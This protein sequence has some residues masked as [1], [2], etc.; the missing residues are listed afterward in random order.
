VSLMDLI[1]E[2]LTRRKTYLAQ[3]YAPYYVASSLLH[4]ANMWNYKNQ[5]LLSAAN[6]YNLRMHTFMI[7]SPGFGKTYYTD[8]FIR[9]LHPLLDETGIKTR[10]MASTTAAGFVGTI[11]RGDD[12]TNP[13][14]GRRLGTA[15]KY[16]DYVV[17]IDEFQSII[18]SMENQHGQQLGNDFLMALD[19]GWVARDMAYGDF[20][21]QTHIT[22]QVGS[23]P[24]RMDLGSGMPRRFFFMV[25]NPSTDETLIIRKLRREQNFVGPDPV[26]KDRLK[27]AWR[28]VISEMKNIS[29][30][31]WAPSV[32][33]YFDTLS[34]D[35]PHYEESLY[36]RFLLGYWLATQPVE[37][38]I[39]V[40]LDPNSR[41]LLA[42]AVKWRN[43]V[44]FGPIETLIITMINDNGHRLREQELYSKLHLRGLDNRTIRN[45][46]KGL[47]RQKAVVRREDGSIV[48]KEGLW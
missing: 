8:Q 14:S 16:F 47:L 6:V 10:F 1:I 3:K 33:K 37:K 46:L 35:M 41:Q 38:N 19:G 25:F 30:V 18:N 4:V 32:Y 13:E 29:S 21:Y 26:M 9:G 36:E 48:S 5:F 2:E 20:S 17:G 24:T 42:Q 22:L 43:S 31:R 23:Q 40:E 7:T 11:G 39:V 34:S 45:Y 12:P 15:E 27:N 44:R 28:A